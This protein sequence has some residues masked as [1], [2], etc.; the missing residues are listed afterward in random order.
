[1]EVKNLSKSFRM[2]ENRADSLKGSIARFFNSKTEVIEDFHALKNISFNLER[3]E[4]LGII[5]ENGAGKSTLLR[6]LSGI[7]QPDE[8]EINF[9]GKAV[10]ILDVGAGFHPELTGRENIYLSAS[11][12]KFTRKKIEER[13]NEIV[14]FSGIES[15]IDEPVKNYSSGMFLRLA[16]AIITCLDADIFLIDEV[17]SVGDANFQ[18]KCKSR[19][20]EL[21]AAGKT[22]LIASHNLNEVVSLCT[23]IISMENGCIKEIG[24]ADVILKYVSRSLPQHFSF[25]P[26]V[27]FHQKDLSSLAPALQGITL[28]NSGLINYSKNQEGIDISAALT[29]FF[30]YK[31]EATGKFSVNLKFY[32][33]TGVLVFICSSINCLDKVDSTG[34]YRLEFEIPANIFNERMYSVDFSI[35]DVDNERPILKID[36]FLILKMAAEK[37]SGAVRD[38]LP[39][40]VK[41]E[42]K[43]SLVKISV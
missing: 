1:M 34:L 22:L 39:G 41:P 23:R 40:I 42:I 17:I 18:A 38:Y 21:M 4:A 15:F 9:Y 6:I 11:L 25:E 14:E 27:V 16:F 13:F 43:T 12:Y 33:I 31:L 2:R 20:Q 10:S 30:E 8:G 7:S 36:K 35:T 32:D 28:G 24:G 26:N 5:G 3:G 37:K 29:I 19:M